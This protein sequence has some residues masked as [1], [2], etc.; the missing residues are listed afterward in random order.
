MARTRTVN[1]GPKGRGSPANGKVIV[2]IATAAG[3]GKE[4]LLATALEQSRFWQHLEKARRIAKTPRAGFKILIKP[5][6]ELFDEKAPTA[7]DPELVEH[8]IDLLHRRG[9]SRVAV[10]GTR[11]AWDLWLE[12]RDVMALAEMAGYRYVTPGGHDYEVADL[13]EQPL[14]SAFPEGSALRGEPISR[15]WLDAHFRISF[16]K[17]KTDDEYG[18][19]LNVQN[20]LGA[21]P[22]CDK[23]FHYHRRLKA[24]E[25]CLALLRRA[26][27]NFSIVDAFV[28]NHGS[29][30]A[31]RPRPL[32]TGAIIASTDPLLADWAASL[33]MGLDPFVSP[34]NACALREIGLPKTHEIIGDLAPYGGWINVPPVLMDSVRK[35][36]ESVVTDRLVAPWLCTV[37]RELF[38]FKDATNDRLNALA[39]KFLGDLDGNPSALSAM[40]ALNYSLAAAR[41]GID[42]FRI[43]FDKDGLKQR[44]A[45]LDF[46]PAQFAP[47]EYRAVADYLEPLERIIRAT[48]P[49]ANGLRWRTIDGSVLF[50]ASQFIDAPFKDFTARVDIHKAV[51]S[52]NDYIGGACVPVARDSAGRVT[53]QA[54]RNIYLPQPNWMVLFGGKVIDV[55]KLEFIRFERDRQS[56]F[57]RT[58]KSGNGSAEFDDGIVT[59]ARRKNQTLVTIFARQKFTLPLFWQFVNIDL[60]PRIKNPLVAQA[61]TNYFTG[62]IANF[63]AQYRGREF[64]AGHPWDLRESEGGAG[65]LGEILRSLGLPE[66]ALKTSLAGLGRLAAAAGGPSRPAPPLPVIDE[67]GFRHFP[68]NGAGHGDGSGPILAAALGE[69]RGFFSDL[70]TAMKKDLGMA[71]E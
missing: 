5:D 52:M 65:G 23:R 57:W 36:N 15:R 27:A 21:L 26:P 39:E 8:L 55:C 35:R 16:A 56:I 22:R 59:F 30:G 1:G 3:A 45:S 34:I 24:P 19:A 48:P 47:V 40:L 33:K 70:S 64:R 14:V 46:D 49:E 61:Y 58:I 38:P 2:A 68:G 13:G 29:A 12:N 25:V 41:G 44:E 9:F 28:S 6:L 51:Q 20:H 50:E 42:A 37:N 32:E 71:A 66:G 62:T 60:A 18:F 54:E 43:L 31:G 4:A 63:I 17:N 10:C 69:A 53:H 7:T 67:D 11:D